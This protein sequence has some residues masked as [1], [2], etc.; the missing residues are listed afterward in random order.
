MDL[1]YDSSVF[2]ICAFDLNVD[3]S[4]VIFLKENNRYQRRICNPDRLH[5]IPCAI[6]HVDQPTDVIGCLGGIEQ[7]ACTPNNAFQTMLRHHLIRVENR[8]E[9]TIHD[10]SNRTV[11]TEGR[12]V[13]HPTDDMHRTSWMSD[14][15]RY[16]PLQ[17]SL[18]IIL[19]QHSLC[20]VQHIDIA[21]IING[22]ITGCEGF[23]HRDCHSM[24]SIGSK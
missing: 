1:Q 23:S 14:N 12:Q 20:I 6:K 13:E 22:D 9:A 16:A 8:F 10:G 24:G 4:G 7:P 3:A 11:A 15:D 17:P 5:R 18:M 21:A 19:I 2:R